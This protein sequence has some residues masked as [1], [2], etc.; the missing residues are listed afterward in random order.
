MTLPPLAELLRINTHITRELL[1]YLV[2]LR[3]WQFSTSY[4]IRALLTLYRTNQPKYPRSSRLRV[5]HRLLFA[6]VCLTN[7]PWLLGVKSSLQSHGP[8]PGG[9]VDGNQPCGA[10]RL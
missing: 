5:I 6:G 9:I 2:P 4:G 7:P 10:A 1:Y 3:I 8:D